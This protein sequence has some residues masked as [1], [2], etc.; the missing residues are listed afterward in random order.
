MLTVVLE[1]INYFCRSADMILVEMSYDK[2]IK[3]FNSLLFKVTQD[4]LA[5]PLGAA[6]NKDGTFIGI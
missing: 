6:V 5:E 1:I 4:I 3:F 2:I